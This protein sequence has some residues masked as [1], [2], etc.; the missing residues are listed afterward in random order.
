MKKS[1]KMF[2]HHCEHTDD[3]QNLKKSKFRKLT[4]FS[5]TDYYAYAC[6]KCGTEMKKEPI[7]KDFD[8]EFIGPPILFCW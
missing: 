3:K 4:E 7:N 5:C 8:K 2:C 1:D 6:P